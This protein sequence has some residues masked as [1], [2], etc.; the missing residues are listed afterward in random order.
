LSNKNLTSFFRSNSE[1]RENCFDVERTD[2]EDLEE[3]KSFSNSPTPP[4]LPQ[5]QQQRHQQQQQQEQHKEPQDKEEVVV[6]L[7]DEVSAVSMFCLNDRNRMR[8]AQ[9]NL[10]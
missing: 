8:N 3:K 1:E 10:K 9:T 5:Q 2:D 4:P 6:T 7:A